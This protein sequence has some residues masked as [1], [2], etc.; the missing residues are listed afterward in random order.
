MI[1]KVEAINQWF[2]SLG[3][4]IVRLR[5]AIIIGLI[6]VT[7]IAVLGLGRIKIDDSIEGWFLEGAAVKKAQDEFEAIFDNND[8]VALLIEADDVFS[9]EILR[10]LKALGDEL[11]REVPFADEVVSLADMEFSRAE[12]DEIIIEDLVPDE[13]PT[14]PAEIERIRTMAFSKDF[15]VNRMFTDDSR[16]TWL[17]LRLLNFPDDWEDKYEDSPMNLVGK[18]VLE[19]LGQEKYRD[20]TIKPT[21]MPV[22][23]VEEIGYFG[24]EFGRLTVLAVL[25]S[26]I[27]LAVFLRSVRG[28]VIP[29]ITTVIS[30]VTVFGFMG[31]LGVKLNAT[32]M[33]VPV[34]LGFAVSIGYS[35]HL[36]NFYKRNLLLT[37]K[38]EESV[39][40]AIK[41]TGWPIFFTAMTTIASL[42]S[43]CFIE[44]VPLRWLGLTS[45][46]TIFSVYIVVMTLTP[47]LLYFG[48]DKERTTEES[49]IKTEKL[50]T[51]KFFARLG[52]LVIRNSV[53]IIILFALTAVIFLYGM[54]KLKVSMDIRKNMGY[55]VPYIE[56]VLRIAESKIG[57]LMSYDV[58][59]AFE[60]PDAIKDPEVLKRFETFAEQV[61]ELELTKRVTSI[62]DIVKDMNMLFNDDNPEYY[63]IPNKKEMV[64]Q[65]LLLYEMSGGAEASEWVNDD[66]S[67]LRLMV[68]VMNMND[69]EIRNEISFLKETAEEIFPEAKFSITGSM[70]KTSALNYYVTIGQI[71]SFLIALTV[72]TILMIAV[73][74]SL[75]TGLIGMIPNVTPAIMVGGLM[76]FLDIPLDFVTITMMPL[77]LGLAVDDTIHFIN[78]VNL[79]YSRTDNYKEGIVKTFRMVGKALFMTTFI[80]VASF[81][82]YLTSKANMFINLGIFIVLGISSALV[83]DYLVTPVLLKWTKPFGGEGSSGAVK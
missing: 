26:I 3:K 1:K 2:E 40:Y 24:N 43:F 50:W 8:Y 70:P 45:A 35:I 72:I 23:A 54:T 83:A 66:Y 9:F 39:Y 28:V 53:P 52:E 30:I 16:Q 41:Q 78:H 77:I 4:T 29:L 11:E 73:F 65:L 64:A 49:G 20:Y 68:E 27:I 15:L 81:A 74:R 12:G 82:I 31:Y 7:V 58:T 44:L 22:M 75:K 60:E 36:F 19:I 32:V 21:G 17:M 57:S 76:G 42:L 62:L 37:G 79:E 13:I 61:K 5:W 18:K 56:R 38:R 6:V 25:V 69:L 47:S 71:K 63:Q 10:L 14:D 80:I 51:D 34:F 67:V 46:A 55:R 48:K 59:F 33:T